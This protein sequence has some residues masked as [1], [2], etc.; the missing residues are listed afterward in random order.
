M[1]RRVLDNPGDRKPLILRHP[2]F[3]PDAPRAIIFRDLI[4]KL[5]VLRLECPKC[6]RAA[7]YRSL[8]WS[9]GTASVDRSHSR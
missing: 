6:G 7:Q 5:D 8:R 1:Q 4:G 3:S 2:A 9:C